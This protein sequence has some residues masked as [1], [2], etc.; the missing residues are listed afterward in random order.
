ML[1]YYEL[2][3]K[4]GCTESSIALTRVSTR[5]DE[6]LNSTSNDSYL[7]LAHSP[8]LFGTSLEQVCYRALN[9]HYLIDS[10]L[11]WREVCAILIFC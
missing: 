2:C 4:L 5:T 8:A 11:R 3:L 10:I 9:C 7:E 1:G 6:D